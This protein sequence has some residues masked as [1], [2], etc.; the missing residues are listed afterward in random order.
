MNSRDLI[1]M[2]GPPDVARRGRSTESRS[3]YAHALA[4][5]VA[6]GGGAAAARLRCAARADPRPRAAPPGVPRTRREAAG[7]SRLLE[8]YAA[9]RGLVADLLADGAEATVPATVRET[10]EA[11]HAPQQRRRRLPRA[12]WRRSSA[13]T[14]RPRP[15]RWQAARRRGY[16]QERGDAEGPTRRGSKTADPLP[17]DVEILPAPERLVEERCS[18]ASVPEGNATPPPAPAT[19]Y[20]ELSPAEQ[21]ELDRLEAKHGDPAEGGAW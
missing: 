20:E 13:S 4:G 1:R 15:R 17:D 3:P 5:L 12:S 16:P 19:P 14:S 8:D 9:V 7:S 10:V 11:V 21:A 18:V 6:A 2:A